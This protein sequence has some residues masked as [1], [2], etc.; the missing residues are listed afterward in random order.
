MLDLNLFRTDRGADL[1]V[2]RASQ[3]SRFADE[4]L[5]DQ[6][7][8]VDNKCREAS[9]ARGE[10]SKQ[11][12]ALN[13]EI[14]NLRK[15]KQDTAHLQ[16][17]SKELKKQV[18]HDNNEVAYESDLPRRGLNSEDLRSHPDLTHML[19]LADLEAGAAVSGA[20]GYFLLHEGVLL[21]QA[22][23]SYSLHFLCQRGFQP[24]QTPYWL[25]RDVMAQCAQ[26]SQFDDEL[27]R[28][29]AG[30]DADSTRSSSGQGAST[31]GAQHSSG[32]SSGGSSRYLI[33]T[34]EQALCAMHADQWLE[35][36]DLPLR[37][38]GLSTCF[39]REA[40]S[41]GKDTLGIFRVHQ[42]DKVE[43]FAV[44]QPD[45]KASW[46]MMDSMVQNA[47]DFYTSLGLPHR[48]VRIVSGALNLSA[49]AKVDLEGWFPASKT[50]RELVSASN[51][52]DYQSR[53]LNVRLRDFSSKQQ[54]QQQQQQQQLQP[55]HS[56]STTSASGKH[57]KDLNST[58]SSHN[59]SSSSSSSS[60]P[61]M[62]NCTLAATRV[63]V[64]C[65]MENY[66]TREGIQVPTVLQPYMHGQDF[67]PFR[68]SLTQT[69]LLVSSAMRHAR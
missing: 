52:T 47:Q 59:G 67:I 42:F 8:E 57:S 13:K 56:D 36:T 30:D 43:Q 5:V 17:L 32:S 21:N 10:L 65:I 48:L 16:G 54:Q 6:V 4:K 25:Q 7:H 35:S 46:Q 15:A 40:G 14:A 2:V 37:Y 26:L 55:S 69:G 1:E 3:R 44:T 61:H 23:I 49:A 34:S 19:G 58:G 68:R 41:H 22:L 39:R 29:T 33:A 31:S 63:C 50:Y 11:F 20:R 62:L 18:E 28:V 38:A 45:G 27:Y 53:N 24:V 51:C 9:H 60:H 66:Q 12:N 64:C